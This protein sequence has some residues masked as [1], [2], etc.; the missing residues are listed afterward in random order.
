MTEHLGAILS[1]V[2]ALLVAI[3]SIITFIAQRRDREQKIRDAEQSYLLQKI[4]KTNEE[5]SNHLIEL[6]KDLDEVHASLADINNK[7][8]CNE[9]D[10]LRWQIRNFAKELR[11]GYKPSLQEF[12]EIEKD[13]ERYANLGGNGFIKNE[14]KYIK[15]KKEGYFDK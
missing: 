13:Y 5:Q 4:D 15:Q 7:V 2:A 14:V 10:R 11:E 9:R 12:E 1:G 3:M 6:G 8:D